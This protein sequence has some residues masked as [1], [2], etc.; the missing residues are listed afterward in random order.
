MA[1]SKEKPFTLKIEAN[2][3]AWVMGTKFV[4][5]RDIFHGKVT[6]ELE[7]LEITDGGVLIPTTGMGRSRREALA[8]CL[9]KIRGKLLV[10]H[11]HDPFL[12]TSHLSPRTVAL[13]P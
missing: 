6:C 1:K 3:L 13:L 4:F 8:D 11:A 12:R 5:D 7:F 9:K 2:D 10:M